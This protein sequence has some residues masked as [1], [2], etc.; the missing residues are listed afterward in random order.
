MLRDLLSDWSDFDVAQHA[1]GICLGFMPD[2]S[3][4]LTL[5]G[6]WIFWSANPMGATLGRLLHDLVTVGVLEENEDGQFRYNASFRPPWEDAV[7]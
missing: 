5:R 4:F 3:E 7:P 2:D 6:K 1:L